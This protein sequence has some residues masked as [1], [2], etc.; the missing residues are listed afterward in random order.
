MVGS[1]V[2]PA[3]VFVPQ[4]NFFEMDVVVVPINISNM[5][6][7][8]AAFFPQEKRIKFYDSMGGNGT[9]KLQHLMKYV[10]DEWKDKKKRHSLDPSTKPDQSEWELDGNSTSALPQQK[11]G[12]VVVVVS[13]VAACLC[14]VSC[15]AL[16]LA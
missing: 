11:N 13:L 7:T 12:P 10:V 2:T 6:W 9:Q 15:V 1:V 8:M 3:R 14:P 4:W 5:H 16:L